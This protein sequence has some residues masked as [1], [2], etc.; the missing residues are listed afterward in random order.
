MPLCTARALACFGSHTLTPSRNLPRSR[1]I[2]RD[3]RGRILK[4]PSLLGYSLEKRYVPRVARCRLAG[5]PA[6]SA[7]STMALTDARFNKSVPLKDDGAR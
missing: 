1:A 2:S 7:L 6:V 5:L 3:H 4:L